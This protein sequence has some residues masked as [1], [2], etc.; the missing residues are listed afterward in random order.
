MKTRAFVCNDCGAEG[1]I[2]STESEVNYCPHCGSDDIAVL[3]RAQ[4]PLN[5]FEDM[6]DYRENDDEDSGD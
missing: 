5:T 4:K 3:N 1:K 2:T 6:D